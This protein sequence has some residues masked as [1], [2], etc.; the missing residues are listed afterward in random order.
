[1][2][3]LLKNTGLTLGSLVFSLL[4]AELALW[5]VGF[6][7]ITAFLER[8]AHPPNSSEYREHIEFEYLFKTN[9]HGLKYPELPLE[10]PDG[11]SRILVLG[12][13]FVEGYGLSVEDSFPPRVEENFQNA[14]FLNA[15]LAGVGPAQYARL[16]HHKGLDLNLTGVLL[17][18]TYN[19]PGDTPPDMDLERIYDK[20]FVK[21]VQI[22][23]ATYSVA[24]LEF[25]PRLSGLL[26]QISEIRRRS[27]LYE[28]FLEETITVAKQQGASD[29]KIRQWISGLDPKLVEASRT[30]RFN[31][32]IITTGLLIPEYLKESIDVHN[33]V[34]NRKFERMLMILDEIVKIAGTRD[35]PVALVFIP[36]YYHYYDYAHGDDNPWKASGM[37]IERKWLTERTEI[38]R[39]LGQWAQRSNVPY[40]DLTN[41]FRDQSTRD[42][43]LNFPLDC[44]WTPDGAAFAG[45]VTADWL[46]QERIFDL[47]D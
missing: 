39:R 3:T 41:S 36:S 11:E 42:D 38:Q 40:L 37:I 27:S 22:F 21:E 43:G 20:T 44:H 31:A 25:I 12:D 6:P 19:D 23:G 17:A 30:N 18:V 32:A 33:D 24:L 46:K 26:F 1:M 2:K 7:P 45:K 9:S 5:L 13:S 4:L 14:R 8:I 28:N 10:R 15:G 34:A 47:R 35:L 16:L 29:E